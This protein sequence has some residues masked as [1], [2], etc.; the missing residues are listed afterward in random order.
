MPYF[1]HNGVNFYYEVQGEGVPVVFSHGL[2]GDLSQVSELLGTLPQVKLVLYDNRGH[3]KTSGKTDPSKLTFLTM[4]DDVAALLDQLKISTAVV[5]GVSMGAGI[6][7]TFSLQH[8]RGVRGL[9]LSRPAW[10]NQPCPP[11]LAIF[12]VIADK[13]EQI[14]FKDAQEWFEQSD[15]FRFLKASFPATAESLSRLFPNVRAEGLIHSFRFI[16]ASTPFL[17]FN[18]LQSIKAPTLILS[19]R[20]DPIHPLAYAERLAAAMPSAQFREFA[21]KSESVEEHKRQFHDHIIKFL[22]SLP[23]G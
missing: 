6:A 22:E 14:G 21:S 2:G 8:G 13:V 12:P 16:P 7:L 20:F 1:Y 3:G 4:A 5:G 19:N 11:N 10:L 18:E 9:I 23:S 15:Y 17:S